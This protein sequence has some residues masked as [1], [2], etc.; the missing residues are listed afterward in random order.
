MSSSAR[1]RPHVAFIVHN[2][3]VAGGMEQQ[4]ARLAQALVR[5]GLAVTLVTSAEV[6][7]WGPLLPRGFRILDAREGSSVVRVPFFG[8]WAYADRM[9]LLEAVAAHVLARRRVD[10]IYG[11][12][13]TGGVHAARVAGL[14]PRPTAV[15]F[16]C[17]GEHG[18]FAAVARSAGQG[19]E[20]A[21]ARID[22]Y[23]C[24]SD[25]VAREASAAGLA[26][27]RFARIANGVSLARFS[28]EGPRAALPELGLA[29][30]RRVIL[31]VGRHD[32]QKRLDV[33]LRAMP[34]ILARVPG[35]RLAC[36]GRGPDRAALEALARELGVHDRVAFLGAREDVP[37]LLRAASVLVL[38]SASE[39]IPNVVLEAFASGTPVVA[40]DI[41]G[42]RDVA[43]HE[44]EALL[45][46]VGDA[47]ALAASVVRLLEDRALAER[48]ADAARARVLEEFDLERIA[49]RY[50]ELFRAIAPR[51]RAALR[52]G[53]LLRLDLE[54]ARRALRYA[55]L[56]LFTRASRVLGPL[57]R[58]RRAPG[59][60]S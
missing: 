2:L 38:P 1:A 13:F 35:A 9:R 46:P 10:V 30:D 23:V 54:V 6:P 44:R 8:N 20:E 29:P 58:R 55:W 53:A 51:K 14:L 4:A 39:G 56:E 31:F 16:A 60:A 19:F 26:R 45:V 48:L 22:R 57:V 27:E 25:E 49:D 15:K 50:A 3:D 43:R 17:A 24:I 12:Q 34:A 40:T 52:A 11:V 21:L 47:A 42:T 18:D 36:A 32:A 5:R 7:G 28:P 33:L 41:P 37:G 59:N